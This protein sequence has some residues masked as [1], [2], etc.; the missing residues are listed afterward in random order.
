[1]NDLIYHQRNGQL[2]TFS[3]EYGRGQHYASKGPDHFGE[4]EL[5]GVRPTPESVRRVAIACEEFNRERPKWDSKKLKSLVKLVSRKHRISAKK[6]ETILNL[7]ANEINKRTKIKKGR[8][9]GG[10][11]KKKTA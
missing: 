2:I 9:K 8:P 10:K 6:L 7:N 4:Y 1:M 3:P 5:C 11:S